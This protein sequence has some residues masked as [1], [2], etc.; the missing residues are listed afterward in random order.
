MVGDHLVKDIAGG[1]AA[2][3]RTVW[4]HQDTSSE[5]ENCADL[6]V[7]DVIDGIALLREGPRRADRAARDGYG[8]T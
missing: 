8:G 7:G 2:G 6:V 3:L 5:H 1:R 4:I